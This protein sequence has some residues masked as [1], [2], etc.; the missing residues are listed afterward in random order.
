MSNITFYFPFGHPPTFGGD[1]VNLEHIRALNKHGF[2]AKV[3]LMKNQTPQIIEAFPKDIPVILFESGMSLNAHDI[4]V[5]SEGIRV[6]YNKLSQTNAF[7]VVVHNQNP[8]YTHIGMDS[9]HDINRYRITKIITPSHYTVKKLEEMGIIK[10]MAVISPYIPEYFK[11]AEKSNEEIRITYSRRK[12]EEESKI[13]LFYLR[14]LY[15]G[16][17][18]LH[19]RNLTNYK[20]EEVAEEMSKAHIY[21]SFAERESLGLMALEAMASGCHVVGFSGFTDFENQD[22]FNEENGDW[23]KEG[24]YK[25]FAE[26]LIEAIEQ[27]E[28]NTPSPKIENG[29]ALVNSRFRQDRFEQEVVRVYQDI[30]DNLPPLEGFNESDK[31]VLDFW[32]FD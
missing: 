10:P 8:F 24:E 5:L 26:K 1:F 2:S 27:I 28:N 16:K 15:R 31:V 25:K 19:I 12:R 3:L 32:H 11:P 4:F 20:R 9:A 22:V 13:L 21:A 18:A 7:H 17:K 23:V 14:S 30:L 6:M 29:L